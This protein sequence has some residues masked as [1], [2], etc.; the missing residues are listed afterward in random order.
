[1]AEQFLDK[2]LII[3]FVNLCIALSGVSYEYTDL[4]V[5]L[6]LS[7][8]QLY[9]VFMLHYVSEGMPEILFT[10]PYIMGSVD[11]EGVG[12]VFCESIGKQPQRWYLTTS[13]YL[14]KQENSCFT[15][16]AH[17]RSDTAGISW[18]FDIVGEAKSALQQ[19]NDNNDNN[20]WQCNYVTIL[21][22]IHTSLGQ[23]VI[24]DLAHSVFIVWFILQWILDQVLRILYNILCA[25]LCSDW[26]WDH[27][28]YFW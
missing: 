14:S 5:S 28:R 7:F 16:I 19:D 1:M 23:A 24:P 27:F 18:N 9:S 8:M 22:D 10:L 4:C 20:A 15:S 11:R 2:L 17:Q 6:M 26:K 25:C 3:R 21:P 12:I 13:S